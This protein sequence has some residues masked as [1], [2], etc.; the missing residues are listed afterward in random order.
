M[1]RQ[2]II[3]ELNTRIADYEE[4]IESHPDVIGIND[5]AKDLDFYKNILHHLT[6]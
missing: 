3:N 6:L 5:I 2:E 1:N 4:I